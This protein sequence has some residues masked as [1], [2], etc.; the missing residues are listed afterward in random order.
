MARPPSPGCA[1]A[2]R[3]ATACLGVA[4][5]EQA[6]PR[7]N[8]A[9]SPRYSTEP[10]AARRV[11]PWYI[12]S[13]T[14]PAALVKP[15]CGRKIRPASSEPS[16]ETAA[17]TRTTPVKM[18]ALADSM[19]SRRGIAVIVARIIPVLYSPLITKTASTATIAWP[20]MTPVRLVFV[21]SAVH[22]AGHLTTLTAIALTPTVSTTAVASSHAVLRTVLSLVHSACTTSARREFMRPS[23][24]PR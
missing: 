22:D 19:T 2:R 14:K 17:T 24:A 4:E 13:G 1:I 9:I 21:V 20:T 5:L 11:G 8:S 15:L 10:I 18:M 3:C 12:D 7:L 16:T 23:C 6:T